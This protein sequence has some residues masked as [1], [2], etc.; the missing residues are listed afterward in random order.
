MSQLTTAG[1]ASAD[2][3]AER[4]ISPDASAIPLPLFRS[5]T[6]VSY[7]GNLCTVNYV[8]IRRGQ[9]MVHLRETSSPVDAD[10]LFLEPTRLSFRRN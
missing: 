1:F 10:R 8:V 9:L 7:Q 2:R 6:R 4:S 5:G 3:L